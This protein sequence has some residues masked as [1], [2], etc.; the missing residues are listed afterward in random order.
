MVLV[1]GMLIG[2]QGPYQVVDRCSANGVYQVYA[3]LQTKDNDEK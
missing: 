2:T 3:Q 1:V